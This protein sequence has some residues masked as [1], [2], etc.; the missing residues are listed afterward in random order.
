MSSNCVLFGMV[1]EEN[2]ETTNSNYSSHPYHCWP[3]GCSSYQT[4]VGGSTLES[5]YK[6]GNTLRVYIDMDNNKYEYGWKGQKS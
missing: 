3:N 1:P 6:Q 4:N 5:L 2:K